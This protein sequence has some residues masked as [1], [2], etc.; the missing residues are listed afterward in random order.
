VWYDH[1]KTGLQKIGFKPS[2]VDECVFTRGSTIFM[3]YVDDGIFADPDDSKI[4]EAIEDLRKI[5]FDI[6]NRGNIQDYL[7]IHVEYLP[8]NRIKLSQPHLID[9]IIEQVGMKDSKKTKKTPAPTSILHRFLNEESFDER[10]HYRSVVGKLNFLEKGTRPDIAYTTHQCARFS[11]DTKKSHGEAIK[12]L[13]KYLIGTRDKGIILNPDTEQSLKVFVDA[14]FCGS[15]QR[16]TAMDDVS[17]AKSRTGYIIQYCNCPIIWISKLQTLVTLSTTEAEYVALSHSLRDTFPI[18]NLL[19]EFKERG[20]NI[21][22][23]GQ[24]KI[25][26][27]VFEDNSGALELA[28]VPKMRPRTKHINLVYHHFRSRVKTRSNPNGDVTIEYV[29]TENQLA[30]ILTKPLAAPQFESLRK[31]IQFF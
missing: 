29:E 25:M 14:D 18:M 17:T 6:E 2:A 20:F 13:C 15:Y 22:G 1:L 24:A 4:D 12:Y 9:Q 3:C 21:I 31:R 5:Q 26:C 8:G 19:K 10:F 11:I 23:N 30:D 16:M 27:R 7:G 28:N